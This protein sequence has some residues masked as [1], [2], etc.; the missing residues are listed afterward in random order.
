MTEVR[1]QRAERIGHGAESKGH[2]AERTDDRRQ[3]T[4]GRGQKTEDRTQMTEGF[5]F[6]IR[7]RR[8]PIGPRTM[9]R[10]GWGMRNGSAW[11]KGHRVRYRSMECAGG[12]KG[13]RD[14][15]LR[16]SDFGLIRLYAQNERN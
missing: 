11:S 7:T 4:D 10:R 13:L 5:D 8:R 12:S 1:R 15:R 14:L 9:A 2:R 6:G 16:I 3:R